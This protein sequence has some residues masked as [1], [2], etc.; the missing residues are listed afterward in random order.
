MAHGGPSPVCLVPAKHAGDQITSC[1]RPAFTADSKYISYLEETD[2]V[3]RPSQIGQ[4]DTPITICRVAVTGGESVRL[5]DS[6]IAQ[7]IGASR[8]RTLIAY[9]DYDNNNTH[10]LDTT[11]KELCAIKGLLQDISPDDSRV[12]CYRGDDKGWTMY[13]YQ[14]NPEHAI[15]TLAEATTVNPDLMHAR[16]TPDG[17]SIVYYDQQHGV[18]MMDADLKNPRSLTGTQTTFPE[19]FQCSPEQ[20]RVF[21]NLPDF[22]PHDRYHSPFGLYRVKTDGTELQQLTHKLHVIEYTFSP[23][24]RQILFTAT[25]GD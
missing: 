15:T 4:I 25:P 13:L 22:E 21:F 17:K 11:G 18:R 20:T 2:N 14:R 19:D 10:I 1:L 8:N 12:L 7:V 9:D 5:T 24:G 3:H 6:H 16:F 23:D